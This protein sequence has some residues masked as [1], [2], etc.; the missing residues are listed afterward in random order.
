MII[1]Q[2]KTILFHAKRVVFGTRPI[3]DCSQR[4]LATP[5]INWSIGKDREW[6]TIFLFATGPHKCKTSCRKVGSLHYCVLPYSNWDLGYFELLVICIGKYTVLVKVSAPYGGDPTFGQ[7]VLHLWGAVAKRTWL[8]HFRLK[9]T[10]PLMSK[11]QSWSIFCLD[12]F[13]EV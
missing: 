12:V 7:E 3:Q 10:P 11:L 2:E 9:N 5:D 4:F 8:K 13:V 6:F 1:T